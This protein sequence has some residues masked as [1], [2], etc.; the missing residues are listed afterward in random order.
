MQ[1]RW[2]PPPVDEDTLHDR[3]LTEDT[4]GQLAI[5]H[6]DGSLKILQ[7]SLTG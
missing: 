2:R 3:G 1:L 4:A 5:G 7:C 6:E